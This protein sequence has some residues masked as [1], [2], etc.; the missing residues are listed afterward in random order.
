MSTKDLDYFLE[1]ADEFEQ[2]TA[3]EKALLAEGRPIEGEISSVPPDAAAQEPNDEPGDPE[4]AP[5][6]TPVVLAKDGKHVIPFEE[7]QTAREQARYWQAKAEEALAQQQ[8]TP[9]QT[10]PPE[11]VATVDLKALRRQ[12][13]EAYLLGEDEQV[14]RLEEQIDAEVMRRAE[15]AAYQRVERREAEAR[16][17]A[18]EKAVMAVATQAIAAYPFL[19]HTGTVANHEAIAQVQALSAL[20]ANNGQSPD[21]ALSAAVE[22]VARMYS[23]EAPRKNDGTPDVQEKASAAIAKAMA[24]SPGPNSMSSIPSASVPHHDEAEALLH[25]SPTQLHAKFFGMNPDQI[26]AIVS[27]IL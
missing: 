16:Q 9:Q 14:E 20:Y 26:E 6:E 4:P 22:K 7:L 10:P 27:R 11:D 17:V 19:D 25:M 24:K 3:E 2:L 8:T 15:D 5:A 1:H 23:A 18:V 21:Q 13:R 12:L